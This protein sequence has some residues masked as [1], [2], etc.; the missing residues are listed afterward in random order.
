MSKLTEV[1]HLR[2][3]AEA[4]RKFV[5]GLIGEVAGTVADALEELANAKQDKLTGTAGQMVGFDDAGQPVAQDAPSGGMTQEE[6]DARYIRSI[7]GQDVPQLNFINGF[8][9]DGGV[10]I[11]FKSCVLKGVDSPSDGTDAA[12]KRYVDNAITQAVHISIME[13]WEASY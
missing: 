6:A 9:T 2:A 8:T 10:P 4:S 12:N 7:D 13:S 5:R 11:D 1:E 3:C